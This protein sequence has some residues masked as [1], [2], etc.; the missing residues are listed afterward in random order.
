MVQARLTAADKSL[1]KRLAY[2]M[3]AISCSLYEFTLRNK[4][5]LY[6]KSN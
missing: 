1:K 3:Q 2:I 5:L 6:Q 4:E